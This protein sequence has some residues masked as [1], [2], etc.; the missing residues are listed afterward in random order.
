MGEEPY[1]IDEI[2]NYI[3]NNVLSEEE[4]EFNQMVLYGD[5]VTTKEV[6]TMA[7]RYPMMS[8]Y[9]VIIVK[10]AQNL[11]DLDD[12][13]Y[14]LQKPMSSTI[15]VFCHKYKKVDGRKKFVAELPKVGVLFES[16]KLYDNQVPTFISGYLKEKG[17][18]IEPKA[19]QLLTEFLGTDLSKVVN[20]LDKLS[21]LKPK[22]NLLTADIVGAN[23]GINKDFNNFELLSALV[24]KDVLKANRIVLYFEQNPKN[25]PL[26]LTITVLFNFFSNLM[27]YYYIKDKSPANVAKELGV[28][29]YFVRDYQTAASK[30]NGWKTLQIIALLRTYDAKSKG[31]DS[32]GV[33]DG[34]L[35][36]ELVYM[37]LH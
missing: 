6:I 21:L 15:L 9:V 35:L 20:E 11:S 37:I 8:K 30:Y 17:L 24:N 33:P 26:V 4:R 2:S 7:R 34:E 5:A 1:Y 28:N 36:K 19:T 16:K 31:I 13:A 29:V 14:Y 18:Q 27:L 12:L 3:Q 22:D 32:A 23:V 25:N 10:E